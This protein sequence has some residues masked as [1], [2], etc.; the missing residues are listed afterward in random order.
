MEEEEELFEK[1]TATLFECG[2]EGGRERLVIRDKN[3]RA[4]DKSEVRKG[5]G[6][7]RGGAGGRDRR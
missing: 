5:R 6:G 3:D 4:P 7:E 1:S 2:M